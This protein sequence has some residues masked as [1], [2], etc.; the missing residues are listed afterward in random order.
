MKSQLISIQILLSIILCLY[1]SGCSNGKDA[2]SYESENETT[3]ES[4]KSFLKSKDLK[5]TLETDE[6]DTSTFTLV[7]S[8]GDGSNE[9]TIFIRIYEQDA[10]QIFGY[11]D[12]TI[13]EEHRCQILNAVNNYNLGSALVSGCI[14][15]AGK[16][17]FYLGRNTDGNSYS[18]KAFAVDLGCVLS[19]IEEETNKILRTATNQASEMR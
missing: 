1:F 7:F 18:Q 2:D 15:N 9:S 17:Y 8:G 3:V 12:I 16:L 10:Y 19:A 6:E 11:Q 5:Y 13:P 14:N 4:I